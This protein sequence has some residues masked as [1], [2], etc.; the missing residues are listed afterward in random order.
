M[1][2]SGNRLSG[3]IPSSIRSCIS[4]VYLNLSNNMLEGTIPEDLKLIT[5]LSVLDLAHNQLTGKVPGEVPN[6]RRFNRSS[7]MGLCG[8]PEQLG[9]PPC[10]VQ[11]QKQRRNKS[12]YVI[13][14]AVSCTLL[15][16]V[17]VAVFIFCCCCC[18][19]KEATNLSH[20]IVLAFPINHGNQTFTQRELEI[21]TDGF[22]EENLL[23]RGS[24]G[25]VYK[26][27]M[28]K[29]KSVLAVKVLDGESVQSY[30]ICKRECQIISGIKHRNLVRL[31][32]S[33]WS[34]QFKAIVLE[35][36]GNGN[37]EQHL[38][39]HGLE[40]DSCELKLRCRLGIALDIAHGLQYLHEDCLAQVVHFDLKPQNVLLDN[41]MV[42]HVADF[43]IGKLILADKQ[44]EYVSTTC[45]IRGTVG[46]IAPARQGIEVSTR[47]DV[48]SYGI[49]LL[50]MM[51][52]K[53]PTSELF[54]DGLDLRKWVASAFPNSIMDVLDTS[55]KQ[56][57]SSG[58]GSSS[59]AQRLEHCC[60]QIIDT[61]L[62]C[63][64]ENPHKRPPM[65][66]VVQR[67]KKLWKEQRYE[68]QR[69]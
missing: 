5:Y 39:P 57:A 47:G 25:S 63:T 6:T 48:Y 44:K 29:G 65:S 45:V 17:L 33:A 14:I 69:V 66:L 4:L 7:F 43:G 30:K 50:E 62:M 53:K 67:L 54:S 51:T 18:F 56:E 19:R 49:M 38:Y 21:A 11:K 41:D 55:L 15:F 46:Y 10:E 23:G 3:A 27:I 28:D 12:S 34:S 22:S 58:A 32:G 52:R 20:S 68:R 8:D 24:F 36:V 35:Y 13:A 31:L 1:D 59:D 9:L 16:L 37:L 64:E 26:A 42:A 2:L 61:R 40:I 60:S